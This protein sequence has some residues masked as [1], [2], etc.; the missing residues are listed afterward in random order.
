MTSRRARRVAAGVLALV[1]VAAPGALAADAPAGQMTWALHFSLAPTLFEPAETAG[2]ITPFMLL[3][4]LINQAVTLGFSRITGSI[5]PVTFDF[6]WPPPPPAHD[7]G[8][9]GR[10]AR[11][12]ANP[13]V[14]CLHPTR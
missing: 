2:L 10:P 12:R 11:G 5:I 3:Y 13:A 8:A 9:G 14:S 6:Y 4:A 7:P 1:A